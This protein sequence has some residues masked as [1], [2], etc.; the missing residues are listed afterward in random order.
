LSQLGRMVIKILN[1]L[2]MFPGVPL[3]HHCFHAIERD[4]VQLQNRVLADQLQKSHRDNFNLY[5]LLERQKSAIAVPSVRSVQK[6]KRREA[7]AQEPLMN[8]QEPLMNEQQME[9]ALV[10][11][12]GT[13][14]TLRDIIGLADHPN[15]TSLEKN[16]K[17]AKLL[18]IVEP[19]KAL[20]NLVGL[21]KIKAKAFEIIAHY[22]L[23]RTPRPADLMH[24]VIEGP[25]GV[26][27]TEVGRLLG[28]VILGLGVLASDKFIC[29][30]RSDLVGEFLGQTAPRTQAVIDS[31]LGGILFIDEAYSLG[32]PEKRDSFS[33]ECL[34]TLNQNLTEKKGQFLCI[35]AGYEEELES[36]FFAVNKGLQRRFPV[37]M[38]I[39]GYTYTELHD[40]FLLKA[41]QG[42]W[43]VETPEIALTLCKDKHKY[44]HFHAGDMETLF[45]QAKFSAAGRLLRASTTFVTHPTL[46]AGDV[47][48]AYQQTMQKREK[49]DQCTLDMYN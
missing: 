32:H 21:A 33:K 13:L 39:C 15:R 1:N 9:E 46:I 16:P 34:D 3:P 22:A 12:F 48:E 19:V 37:R 47:T 24:M 41:A 30:R 11:V 10:I 42:H 5:Q 6:R 35:I 44:F 14:F 20:Q 23:N 36:C 25:P 29:A 28:K 26:G 18:G 4:R 38:T 45:C 7:N 49:I 43:L 31:A 2:K 17:F 40:I 27:K 8:A